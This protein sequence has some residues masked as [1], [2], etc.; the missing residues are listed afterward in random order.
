[1]QN[2]RLWSNPMSLSRGS[3]CVEARNRKSVKIT[4]RVTLIYTP[5]RSS[6]VLGVSTL[7]VFVVRASFEAYKPISFSPPIL[8]VNF[9]NYR[10]SCTFSYIIG[11]YWNFVKCSYASFMADFWKQDDWRNDGAEIFKILILVKSDSLIK[12]HSHSE[13]MLKETKFEQKTC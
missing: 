11:F 2:S 6:L 9:E 10:K 3:F 12:S 4:R 7:R 13:Q 8:A 1:M 5:I